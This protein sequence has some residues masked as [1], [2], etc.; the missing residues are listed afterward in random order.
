M[1]TVR[2]GNCTSLPHSSVF[3]ERTGNLIG[4]EKAMGYCVPS[5]LFVVSIYK[6]STYAKKS[7][8]YKL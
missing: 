5:G 6:I 1:T 4:L 8:K 3:L 7:G 2:W